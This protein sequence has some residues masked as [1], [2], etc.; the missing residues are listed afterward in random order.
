[1][2]KAILLVM[3]GLAVSGCA[4]DRKST[5]LVANPQSDTAV[6][7]G[8]SYTLQ[9]SSIDPALDGSGKTAVSVKLKSGNVVVTDG[10][11]AQVTVTLKYRVNNPEGED[12]FE[13]FAVGGKR[14]LTR[15]AT[16]FN[17][18]LETGRWHQLQAETDI[19]DRQVSGKS[20]IF[21]VPQGDETEV[22]EDSP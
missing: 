17:V 2:L 7:G 8:T 10:K 13:E 21:S 3:S 4:G 12:Y 6:A 20:G 16:A 5:G 9:F 18:R 11:L 1:M 15:G 19:N 22:S 14:K